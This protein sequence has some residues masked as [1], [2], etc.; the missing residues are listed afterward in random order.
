MSD[1]VRPDVSGRNACRDMR[2]QKKGSDDLDIGELESAEE[3]TKKILS[4]SQPSYR[5]DIQFMYFV[6]LAL[7]GKP[8]PKAENTA[9]SKQTP[10]SADKS[11]NKPIQSKKPR[12]KRQSKYEDAVDDRLRKIIEG[13]KKGMITSDDFVTLITPKNFAKNFKEN[14][15]RFKIPSLESIECQLR[16]SKA[17]I[18]RK[19]M[20]KTVYDTPTLNNPLPC[21]EPLPNGVHPVKKPSKKQMVQ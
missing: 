3:E 7:E 9:N 10:Q 18:N 16:H 4:E 12:K 1:H 17:W 21:T 13:V 14:D 5:Q 6:K 11:K 20:L 15:D 19:E 2:P 8:L